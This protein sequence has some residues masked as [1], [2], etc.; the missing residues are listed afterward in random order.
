MQ[1]G[2]SRGHVLQ[3][4]EQNRTVTPI[5]NADLGVYSIAVG[6]AQRL[7][8]GNYH[9]DAGF[10]LENGTIDSYSF[11]VDAAGQIDYEAH[12][13][14]ILYRTFRMSDMYTPN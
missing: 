1:G 10:V 12:Q 8:D 9:F 4:D 2:N 6:S 13:N 11:E 3:I 7:R 14:V 5:L